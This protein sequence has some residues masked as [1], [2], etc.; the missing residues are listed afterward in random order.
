[1]F[2]I[3]QQ[4]DSYKSRYAAYYTVMDETIGSPGIFPE[5]TPCL[6]GIVA[7]TNVVFFSFMCTGKKKKKSQT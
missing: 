3:K 6:P 4:K 1:M 2:L 7:I 5:N